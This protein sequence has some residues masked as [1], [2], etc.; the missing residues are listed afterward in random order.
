MSLL[1]L[2][3]LAAAQQ[4]SVER[5]GVFEL[6]QHGPPDAPGANAFD[7]VA[8]ATFTH[9]E[10]GAAIV[11]PSFYDG[12]DEYLTRFSP[13]LAGEYTFVTASSSP[14][15]PAQTGNF[16]ALPPSPGN[17][18]PVRVDR[19]HPRAFAF[20]DGTPHVSVGTTAY[21]WLHAGDANIDATLA[22]LRDARFNKLRM[23]LL[24]KFY[25]WTHTEP[26][27][28]AFARAADPP[29]PCTIC[30]PSQRGAFDLT[31]FN[32]PF[33]RTV[34]RAV[35]GLHAAGV[36]ADIILFHPYDAGHWGLDCL[37][38]D[39]DLRYVRYAAARLGAYS[40]VWW[41][42]ANEWSDLKCKCGGFNSSACPQTYFD[43]LF[44]GLVAA[45][46]HARLR[47]IHNGPLYYNH[48]QP[49]I[50][51]ISM[52]CHGDAASDH[53]FAAGSA[54]VDLARSTW[55]PKPVVLDEVRYEGNI[56]AQWG[57]LTASDMTQRFWLFLSK[58]AYCGHSE[59]VLPAVWDGL[60]GGNPNACLCSPSMW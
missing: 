31:R 4:P 44:A 24:P 47:S 37:G 48:S 15:L 53:P 22:T 14:L 12:G 8:N 39:A 16:T 10:T 40:N 52:Q 51:H 25:P 59:T 54:C 43:E 35:R 11:V 6:T 58:G 36:V 9:S 57:Q 1:L 42:M 38:M 46:A 18:G 32:P 56:S 17:R 3:L 49:W 41:S 29:P 50:D 19:A 33:W 20:A 45:D 26:P 21:A 60:C 23:T 2:P 13:P 55:T 7:V 28:F 30:C 27:E 5:W 34:E